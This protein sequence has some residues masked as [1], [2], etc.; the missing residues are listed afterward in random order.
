MLPVINVMIP[1]HDF[2]Y[3]HIVILVRFFLNSN[4]GFLCIFAMEKKTRFRLYTVY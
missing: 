4:N 2:D 1:C 3:I